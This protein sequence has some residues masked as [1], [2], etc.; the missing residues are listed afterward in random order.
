MSWRKKSLCFLLYNCGCFSISAINRYVSFSIADEAFSTIW[1]LVYRTL[2]PADNTR[3]TNKRST[4][5]S[6]NCECIK[7]KQHVNEQSV[8]LSRH[9]NIIQFIYYEFYFESSIL[10]AFRFSPLLIRQASPVLSQQQHSVVC[11][12][13]HARVHTHTQYRQMAFFYVVQW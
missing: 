1:T 9:H 11:M 3:F 7:I 12:L 5:T 6:A 2:L 13:I 10:P 8:S 4:A